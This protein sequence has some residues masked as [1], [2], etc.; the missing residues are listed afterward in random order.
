M[1]PRLALQASQQGQPEQMGWLWQFLT[2]FW[3]VLSHPQSFSS[4]N[5]LLACLLQTGHP[6]GR[7]CLLSPLLAGSSVPP[8]K[9]CQ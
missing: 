4:E 8:P 7:A 5:P 3:F 9:I 6:W 2:S 1:Y